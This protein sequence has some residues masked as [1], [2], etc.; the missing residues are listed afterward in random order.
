MTNYARRKL[1][2]WVFGHGFDS[3]HLHQHGTR[4]ANPFLTLWGT[5]FFML[6]NILYIALNFFEFWF[7]KVLFLSLQL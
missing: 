2:G 3:R 5:D 1:C 6:G 7:S 4:A